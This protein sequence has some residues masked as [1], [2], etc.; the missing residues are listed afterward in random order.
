MQFLPIPIVTYP[1]SRRTARRLHLLAR[2]PNLRHN[3][4]R[5]NKEQTLLHEVLTFGGF[6][7]ERSKRLWLYLVIIHIYFSGSVPLKKLETLRH[8]VFR[9]VITAH[10]FL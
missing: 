2:L 5:V 4:R 1:C 8:V 6:E 3:T 9:A 10:F 7:S